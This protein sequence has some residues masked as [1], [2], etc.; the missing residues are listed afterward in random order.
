MGCLM[1]NY[2]FGKVRRFALVLASV[3]LLSGFQF[4][5]AA[6]APD[7]D[8]WPRWESHDP[9]ST[10][11]VDHAD[12][13]HFLKLYVE[14]GPDGIN[15]IAYARV[16]EADKQ[17][18][19]DYLARLRLVVIDDFARP[20]QLAYW[21]NLYNALTVRLVL[22]FLPIKSIRDINISSSIFAG[23]WQRKLLEVDDEPLSLNDIEH[24][25]L[26][27]IWRDPRIH[28]AVNCASIGC[29][30]LQPVAFTGD[31]ADALLDKAAHE[32]INHRRGARVE[33]GDLTASKI[34]LWFADDFGGESGVID[35]LRLY[36]GPELVRAL[37]GVQSI[38]DYEYDWGLNGSGS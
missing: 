13:G 16:T 31:T 17:A 36:A 9:D 26:R 33:D 32:Y 3:I 6:L 29:P 23:P 28:Y 14:A 21:I 27:P 37:T 4:L 30:N 15:R 7:A 24:R 5:E 22:D 25:I 38:D 10:A 20:E 34:Y 19:H 8:L 2:A 35:H 12:W 1:D 18:L 11:R